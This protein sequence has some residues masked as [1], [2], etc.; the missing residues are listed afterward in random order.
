MWHGI[1]SRHGTPP[2]HNIPHGTGIHAPR[3]PA[4]HGNPVLL[5]IPHGTAGRGR[6]MGRSAIDSE[7]LRSRERAL[8]AGFAPEMTH[9]TRT[10]I[11]A[12]TAHAEADPRPH[13]CKGAQ[14]GAA[15]FRSLCSL[16]AGYAGD[17]G[18]RSTPC[19]LRGLS[20]ICVAAAFHRRTVRGVYRAG[21]DPSDRQH[22]A[23]RPALAALRRSGSGRQ[24]RNHFL[25]ARVWHKRTQ[26][27]V[28]QHEPYAAAVDFVA[29]PCRNR[30]A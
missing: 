26:Y 16:R 5:C 23:V 19:I 1:P 18:S 22:R 10:H 11:H 9:N 14:G 12:G 29:M 20:C 24:S 6:A 7:R 17:C 30:A 25:G 3:Y 28:A 15:R 2:M 13:L 8:A 4:R 21:R 27:C